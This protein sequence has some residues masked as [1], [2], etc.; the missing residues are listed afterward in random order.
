MFAP[1]LS[2]ES[3]NLLEVIWVAAGQGIE[4]ILLLDNVA[5]PRSAVELFLGV[6]EI[7]CKTVSGVD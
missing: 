1:I 6:F 7:K 4:M 5:P 3:E 2:F